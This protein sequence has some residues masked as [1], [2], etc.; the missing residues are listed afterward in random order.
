MII[1]KIA[2]QLGNQ[3]FTYASVKTLAQ[4]REES[5]YF[6][7]ENNSRINDSDS[8]YGNEIYTI[9][10]NI[11]NEFLKELP[12]R[13][14]H[15]YKEPPL[16]ERQTNFQQEALCVPED[17]L[18]IG[19][20]ISYQ[21]FSHNLDNV[22]K[23][24]TFPHDIEAPVLLEIDGLRQKYPN[25]T[26]VAIHFRVGDDYM[27]QGFRIQ[28]DYWFQAAEYI[29]NTSENQPLFLVFYDQ[30]KK[31]GGIVNRFLSSYDCIVCRGSLIHDLCMMSKCEKQIICNSSFS[32]M[33][34]VLNSCSE[35]E[36]VRPSVYP[37]GQYFYPTDCFADEWTIVPA[38]QNR[39]SRCY[40]FWMV[41]KGKI[42]KFIK[43][44]SAAY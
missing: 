3:M 18:M 12:A 26:F 35:K 14:T 19:H 23:W 2:D 30:K 24:F 25:R 32:I 43:K 20:F 6:I 4:D 37:V 38:K 31:K 21:Y 9:F 40:F 39:L 36:I 22:R 34:A 44:K 28:D 7:R 42:L 17:T 5:F 27:K 8:K 11:Q 13:V 10:P 41:F 15:Q 1:A 33:S 16:P 29:S